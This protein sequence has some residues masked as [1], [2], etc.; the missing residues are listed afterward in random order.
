L[1]EVTAKVTTPVK[2]VGRPK[3][4]TKEAS[5]AKI[6]PAARRLFAERGYSKTTF[7]DVGKAVGM[8]HAALYSYFPSKAALY[9]ATT[10]HAQTDLQPE[11]IKAIQSGANF[12]QQLGGILRIAARANEQDPSITGLLTAI[13]LE[14]SRHPDL[15]ELMLGGQNSTLELLTG[16][17]AEAQAKG[18][19]RSKANP[20]D[21]VVAI[22]GAWVGIT[23][24]QYSLQRSELSHSMD[25]FIELI[26]DGLFNE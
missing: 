20:E 15:A 22:I 14:L 10:E 8:T 24:I 6:L 5:L 17:F 21:L 1:A 7:K 12:K 19:I 26:E 23:M 18:E 4:S 2:G 25:V 13:P 16:V 11:Y 9:V 3:G